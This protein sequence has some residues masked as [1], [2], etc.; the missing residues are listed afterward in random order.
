MLRKAFVVLSYCDF[1]I[2]HY[3]GASVAAVTYKWK[4]LKQTQNEIRQ[5]NCQSKR[6]S[7]SGQK[8]ASSVFLCELSMRRA[9]SERAAICGT[10]IKLLRR[11]H[12]R[13]TASRQARPPQRIEKINSNKKKTN[14]L[15]RFDAIRLLLPLLL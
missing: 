9:I 10:P 5:K 11:W 3:F 14:C 2:L 13:A 8:F 6:R 1:I 15:C 4:S 7:C 12:S